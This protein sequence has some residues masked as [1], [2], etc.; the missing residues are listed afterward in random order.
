MFRFGCILRSN[1]TYFM[2]DT[3]DQTQEKVNLYIQKIKKVTPKE[4]VKNDKPERRIRY[5]SRR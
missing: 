4:R 1:K 5:I 2:A 3:V